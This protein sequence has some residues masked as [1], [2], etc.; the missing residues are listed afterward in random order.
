MLVQKFRYCI[1][2]ISR[3]CS[4]QKNRSLWQILKATGF[5]YT[6]IRK[7]EVMSALYKENTL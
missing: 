7:G 1:P 6:R 5:I 2:S 4:I 3:E